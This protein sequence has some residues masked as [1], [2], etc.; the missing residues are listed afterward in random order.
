MIELIDI[1]RIKK[2]KN[3]MKD[4]VKTTSLQKNKIYSDFYSSNIFLKREDQQKVKS[5]KI[6]GAY[7]KIN[8]LSKDK[9]NKGIAKPICVIG[10]GGVNNAAAVKIITTTYFLLFF[11]NSESTIPIL[12]NKLKTTGNWKLMPKAKISFMTNDKYSFTLASNWIGKLV[13]KPVLS[14]DKKNF[15]AKGIIK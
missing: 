11:K 4:V 13:D 3:A 5:F 8:S 10:S 2:A 12:A 7:N 6:R 14:N 1:Y 9:I 15:I